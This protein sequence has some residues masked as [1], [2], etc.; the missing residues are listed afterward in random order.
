MNKNQYFDKI[1]NLLF[2]DSNKDDL[3]LEDDSFYII[4]R[5]ITQGDKTDRDL[6]FKI[7]NNQQIKEVICQTREMPEQL[8][9]IWL[10]ALN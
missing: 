2:W 1:N 10:K 4:K 6:L 3:I 9:D 8:K 5:V 7:Y